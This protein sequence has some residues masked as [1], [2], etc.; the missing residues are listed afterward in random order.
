MVQEI[1]GPTN[2]GQGRTAQ[3]VGNRTWSEVAGWR[4]LKWVWTEMEVNGSQSNPVGN[5]QSGQGGPQP[6]NFDEYAPEIPGIRNTIFRNGFFAEKADMAKLAMKGGGRR[7]GNAVRS[8][9]YTAGYRTIQG[10]KKIPKKAFRAARRG[11]IGALTGGAAAV[12]AAGT[13]VAMSPDKAMALTGAAFSGGASF[14]NY[15]GDKFAK[16]SGDIAK[17]SEKN[18]WGSDYKQVQQHR[19]DKQLKASP[20][21]IDTLT[22]ILGSRD[23]AIEATKNGELQAVLNSGNTDIKKAGKAIKKSHDYYEKAKREREEAKARGDKKIP[24][25]VSQNQALQR[26]ISMLNWSNEIHPGVFQP[27]SREEVAWKE[28]LTSQLE[29][30]GAS[31]PIA[32][33]RVEEILADLTDYHNT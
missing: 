13:G 33:K 7:I 22:T 20:E 10:A 11:A 18:F 12:V 31:R 26:A 1:I 28:R 3:A 6:Y 5:N 15:Y 2:L 8:A 4:R 19:F 29:A 21:T 24:A 25:K 16:A 30:G 17:G 14:G 27:N 9:G 32:T 23:A